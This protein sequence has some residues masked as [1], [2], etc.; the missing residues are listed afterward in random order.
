MALANGKLLDTAFVAWRSIAP[1]SAA[2]DVAVIGIDVE[3]LR[4]YNDP[5]DFWHAHYGRL[6][7]GLAKARPAV[8]GLDVVLPERSYHH[9]VPGLD[10]ALLKGLLAIRDTTPVVLARTVDDFRNF[11]EIFA[12]YV[13]MVGADSVGAV[14]VCR[15]EDEVIRR[16]DEYLCDADRTRPVA[17]LTGIMAE[18]LGVKGARR[19]W[20]DYHI[21][22]PIQYLPFR[23][24]LRWAESDEAMLHS[25]LD[26]KP[27]LLGFILP[28][29]TARPFRSI[30]RCGSRA[31]ARC[32]ACWCTRRCCARC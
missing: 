9:L 10:Q 28:S 3:D 18:R 8:V 13:A 20:I 11:R 24:V 30:S 16:F 31:T 5:R 25:A 21:G 22:G 29:R 32:L 7:A 1:Q 2:R 15:D 19:G 27:V 12:P 23:E 6:L 17:S 4:K 14:V 26:G